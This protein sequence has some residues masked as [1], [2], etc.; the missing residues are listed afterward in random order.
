MTHHEPLCLVVRRKIAATPRRLFDAWTRPEQL[1]AWWGPRGVRC[2]DAQVDLRIG[3]HYRIDN[4]LPDGSTITI[5]GQFLALDPPNSLAYSWTVGPDEG[6]AEQVTVRF[7]AQG[8]ETE[9]LIVHERIADQR[10]YAD[11][12]GGWWGCLDGLAEYIADPR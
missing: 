6:P 9:V 2:S 3:G 4:V 8:D 5:Q 7:E 11:H 12:E 1:M 10:T